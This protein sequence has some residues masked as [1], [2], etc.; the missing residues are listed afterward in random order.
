MIVRSALAVLLLACA[1]ALGAERSAPVNYVLRCLGCHLQDGTG[2]P[3]AGIPD[4]VGMV[5]VFTGNEEA[6]R[7]LLHV[8]GV[9]NSGLSDNETAAL[10]NYIMDTYA[11]DSMPDGAA[12]FTAEEVGVL[13][14]QDV[15]NVVAYR[16]RI[17]AALEAEGYV[18]ADYPWP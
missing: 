6:R 9:I 3:A 4:F 5:G 7:Y 1:P 16:R 10:L 15:G 13:K 14:A 12:P 2:L 18:V 17:A 8:P 11:G